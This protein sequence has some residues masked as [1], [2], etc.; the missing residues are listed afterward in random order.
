MTTLAVTIPLQHNNMVEPTAIG[1]AMQNLYSAAME[2]GF[3]HGAA[4]GGRVEGRTL[5]LSITQDE[6]QEAVSAPRRGRPPKNSYAA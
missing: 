4:I 1:A 3:G 2:Q 5:V 6:E